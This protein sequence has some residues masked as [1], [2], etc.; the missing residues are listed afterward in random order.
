MLPLGCSCIYWYGHNLN[1]AENQRFKKS[2]ADVFGAEA[3]KIIAPHDEHGYLA[4]KIVIKG[5]QAVNGNVK[6]V[7]R[8]IRAIEKLEFEAPKGPF[9]FYQHNGVFNEYL[10]QVNRVEG[11]LQNTV[12]RAWGPI[13]QGWFEDGLEIPEIPVPGK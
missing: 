8:M 6:D 10:W 5:I 12:V 4:A 7:D 9:K 2:Y 3:A 1:T 13:R 11:R